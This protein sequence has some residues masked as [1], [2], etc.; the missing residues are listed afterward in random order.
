MGSYSFMGY[1]D[2]KIV[3]K[4]EFVQWLVTE[5]VGCNEY[6]KHLFDSVGFEDK[7][8]FGDDDSELFCYWNEW[9]IQSYWYDSF[10]CFLTK[11]QKH[12]R[13]IVLMEFENGQEFKIVFC[14]KGVYVVFYTTP[15]YGDDDEEYD[16][17][18]NQDKLSEVTGITKIEFK[19]E[20]PQTE[21]YPGKAILNDL[22]EK[23]WDTIL[24]LCG[25]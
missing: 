8:G 10:C 1:C 7:E 9:K 6:M 25:N 23:E 21:A 15:E 20:D 14:D 4:N 11:L 19:G 5:K 3:D 13:G 22:E 17:I 24:T 2:L 16:N 12:V 18:I